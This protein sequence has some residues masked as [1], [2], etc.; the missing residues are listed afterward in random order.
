MKD[1]RST[2]PGSGSAMDDA[3]G[4]NSF[5]LWATASGGSPK[6][7]GLSAM[8]AFTPLNGGGA[9]DFYLAQ[10]DA[11]HAGKTMVIKLWD[12]GD[13]GNLSA[14]LRILRPTTRALL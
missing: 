4:H 1:T 12:P 6:I 11:E 9:A 14:A 10:I 8:E 3:N 7:H 13:T 5:S 2:D